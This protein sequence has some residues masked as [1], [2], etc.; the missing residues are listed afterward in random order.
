MAMGEASGHS[1]PRVTDD[2]RQA[3]IAALRT[4]AGDGRIDLDEFGDRV[5]AVY[6]ATSLEE[7][8]SVLADVGSADLPILAPLPPPPAP[9]P[10]PPAAPEQA[11]APP[12]RTDAQWVVAVMSGA[13]RKGTWQ[14]K[15]EVNAVAIM[16]GCT[17]DFRHA[18]LSGPVTH[19]SALAIMGG[20]E[21]VVPEGVPVEVDGFVLMGGIEDRTR[22]TTAT[23]APMLRIKAYGMWGGVTVRH[24]RRRK[25]PPTDA[26]A[27]TST[28]ARRAAASP[29]AGT[30]TAAS[31][32]AGNTATILFTD[33][34]DSTSM[35]E[36]MGDH[37]WVELLQV[38]NELLREH[39]ERCGGREI[40]A[41]GDGFMV[42]FASARAAL[43]CAVE[44][45]RALAAHRAQHDGPELHVRIG[46]HSGEVVADADD[47]FG[48]NVI[49][50]SRIANHA[51]TDQILAS[52]LTKALADS[53]ND[54][55][56]GEGC[57]LELRGL[58]G[59]W[60]VHEV[61]W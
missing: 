29:A 60:T 31:P 44:I 13:N 34:I 8:R 17:L 61:R 57:P 23:G 20:I 4:A 2:H 19:V 14:A 5:G 50:A 52:A 49:V 9:L 36:S 53:G 37:R 54:L 48:R 55:D 26:V 11:S 10:P 51:G 7:L 56:F 28:G 38:H 18:E 25:R 35:A 42:S 3:S 41:Q 32:A 47:L 59:E 24:P 12:P 58:S 46:L 16:G 21:I 27:A 6:A 33:L 15:T 43:L 1:A 45:Q 40:K 22:P 30:V 39:F